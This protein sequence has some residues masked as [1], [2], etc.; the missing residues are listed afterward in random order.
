MLAKINM[1][2]GLLVPVAVK[3]LR[4]VCWAPREYTVGVFKHKRFKTV[5]CVPRET[6]FGVYKY[7]YFKTVS[8]A[9]HENVVECL[10]R[11]V[12][13]QCSVHHTEHVLIFK[14]KRCRRICKQMEE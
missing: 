9:P 13:T 14:Y 7:E 11:G 4:S 8:Y 10:N 5:Y 12:A 1:M 2:T 6:V 3:N